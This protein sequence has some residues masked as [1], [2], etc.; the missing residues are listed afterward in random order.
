MDY[1]RLFTTGIGKFKTYSEGVTLAS[2]INLQP[3]PYLPII[4]DF[5]KPGG[6]ETEIVIEAGTIVTLDDNGYLIPCTGGEDVTLTYTAL[7]VTYG[8]TDIDT[9]DSTPAAVSA[10]GTSTAKL[11]KNA[12]LG[13]LLFDAERVSSD[14]NWK[15]QA[16]VTILCDFLVQ[17][18]LPTAYASLSWKPGCDVISDENGYVIPLAYTDLDEV[19]DVALDTSNTYADAD[20]NVA[21]NAAITE[22]NTAIAALNTYHGKHKFRIGK[23]V[24]V[25]DMSTDMDKNFTGG[26][27]KVIIPIPN[28]GLPGSENSGI[29]DGMDATTKKAVLVQLEI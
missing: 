28:M 26:L 14:L 8:V 29:Q 9:M 12:P 18:A 24:R 20:V 1:N 4:L 11:A 23:C 22:I 2:G 5:K 13:I 19:A 21:V 10:A 7:D 6:K 15:P 3:A 25:I 27:D 16:G 17:Y